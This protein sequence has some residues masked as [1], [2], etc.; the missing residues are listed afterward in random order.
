MPKTQKWIQKKHIQ[1]LFHFP[2]LT[3][4]SCVQCNWDA[5]S[6][7]NP[8][9]R[10]VTPSGAIESEI[11]RVQISTRHRG[12]AYESF[13]GSQ[14]DSGIPLFARY[15][16]TEQKAFLS[17]LCSVWLMVF[18]SFQRP[19]P[20]HF[21]GWIWIII[22]RFTRRFE[23][24]GSIGIAWNLSSVWWALAEPVS[25]PMPR[26]LAMWLWILRHSQRWTGRISTGHPSIW[27]T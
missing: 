20:P 12:S 16:V 10:E 15:L 22:L 23:G 6:I 27:D 1:S 25:I 26:W 13:V 21:R 7:P 11:P 18:D 8:D 2:F 24:L 3:R 14:G 19:Q 17:E 4:N 5:T 9:A